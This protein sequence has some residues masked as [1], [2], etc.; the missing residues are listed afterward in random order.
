[1]FSE[2]WS[3]HIKIDRSL[4]L[5]QLNQ[6]FVSVDHKVTLRFYT[7]KP[8]GT[9]MLMDGLCTILHDNLPYYVYGDKQFA[10]LGPIRAALHSAHYF[11][12]KDPN[13][14]G[15]YGELLLFMLV[16]SLLG[17]KMVAHKIR[18]LTNVVDQVKGGDGIFIGNYDVDGTAH[19]AYLIGESKVTA[20]FSNALNEALLSL[21]RFHEGPE[22]GIFREHE[23]IIA[24]EFLRIV[25]T[26]P[27]ELYNRLTPSTD[28][29]KQQ[30]VVHPTLLMYKLNKFTKLCQDSLTHDELQN[31]IEKLFLGKQKRMLETIKN[32]VSP[33]SSLKTV[34]LDF[35]IFPCESVDTF[36]RLMYQ[37]I[38]AAPYSS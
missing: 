30:V 3:S 26:D 15:K 11:G 18:A 4:V 20:S 29:F 31:N 9:Q 23:L 19:P 38:H 27:D 36:R 22:A 12:H 5:S 16:E 13:T 35:F 6:H 21:N 7:L 2:D 24:K 32:K 25:D 1:M 10:D 37:K 28:A 14:D 34:Y 17:C 33:Y 8:S